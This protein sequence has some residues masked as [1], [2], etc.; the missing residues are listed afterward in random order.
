V[1]GGRNPAASRMSDLS[2]RMETLGLVIGRV[3]AGIPWVSRDFPLLQKSESW[4]CEISLFAEVRELEMRDFPLL[5]KSKSWK[6]EIVTV[7]VRGNKRK[8]VAF[9]TEPNELRTR[10]LPSSKLLLVQVELF[11]CGRILGMR[12]QPFELRHLLAFALP[13][14]VVADKLSPLNCPDSAAARHR[15]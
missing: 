14:S 1:E 7:L 15:T 5:Q 10:L 8:L 3:W 11:P 4:K 13:P 2:L 12:D 9:Q 6:C